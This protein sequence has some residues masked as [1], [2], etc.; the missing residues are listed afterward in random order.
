MISKLEQRTTEDSTD[1]E[2]LQQLGEMVKAKEGVERKLSTCYSLGNDR[3]SSQRGSI[4]PMFGRKGKSH[5]FHSLGKESITVFSTLGD[6]LTP[7]ESSGTISSGSYSSEDGHRS[8]DVVL[9][10]KGKEII[11]ERPSDQFGSS[12]RMFMNPM[13]IE[14]QVD[15]FGSEVMGGRKRMWLKRRTFSSTN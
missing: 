8:E 13:Y 14:G 4:L 10:E 6:S 2:A 9:K 1:N 12:S 7:E 11:E 15:D 5:S 3:V